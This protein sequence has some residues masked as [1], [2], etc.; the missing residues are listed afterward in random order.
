ML[1]EFQNC[2]YTREDVGQREREATS[3]TTTESVN[4]SHTEVECSLVIDAY[5][6]CLNNSL[7]NALNSKQTVFEI[8]NG[9]YSRHV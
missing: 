4:Q 7:N 6:T 5:R 8:I 2:E 1:K 9:M 3:S